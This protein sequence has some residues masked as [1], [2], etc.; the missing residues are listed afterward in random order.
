[1]YTSVTGAYAELNFKGTGIEIVG[2]RSNFYGIADVELD[3][4]I[5]GSIDYYASVQQFQQSLF[6][7]SDLADADH[8]IRLKYTGNKSAASGGTSINIDYAKV[9]TTSTTQPEEPVLTPAEKIMAQGD[10]FVLGGLVAI[11]VLMVLFRR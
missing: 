11:G 5:I 1:M 7:V 2:F 8:V 4:Q 6:L 3:G 9:T 10:F